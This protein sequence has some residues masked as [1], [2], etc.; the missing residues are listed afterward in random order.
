VLVE[1]RKLWV[2]TKARI[3]KW[4][5]SNLGMALFCIRVTR[6]ANIIRVSHVTWSLCNLIRCAPF[7][8]ISKPPFLMPITFDLGTPARH[9]MTR[10]T[11][12]TTVLG[13]FKVVCNKGGK[14]SQ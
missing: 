6:Q 8:H 1:S 12:F 2:A 13:A 9:P 7:R 10:N 14:K 4:P 11:V 5:E 3:C